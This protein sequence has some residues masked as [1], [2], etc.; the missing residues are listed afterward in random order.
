[1]NSSHV[2][3]PPAAQECLGSIRSVT[4]QRL[5]DPTPVKKSWNMQTMPS[6]AVE[7]YTLDGMIT[8]GF[9]KKG[10]KKG[11]WKPMWV[12]KVDNLKWSREDVDGAVI[13]ITLG[14]TCPTMDDFAFG[15]RG[16]EWLLYDIKLDNLECCVAGVTPIVTDKNWSREFETD[17]H[18]PQC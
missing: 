1:M 13:C 9:N 10:K 4:A 8:A 16:L 6:T 7:G 18:W 5:I 12:Y 17:C 2:T 14:E 15:K 3:L 11:T